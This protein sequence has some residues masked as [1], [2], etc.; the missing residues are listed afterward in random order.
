MEIILLVSGEF[1]FEVNDFRCP[2]YG[3]ESSMNL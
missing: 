3:V 2:G 1:H